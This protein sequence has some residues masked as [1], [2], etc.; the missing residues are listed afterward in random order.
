[1]KLD[2]RRTTWVYEIVWW[3]SNLIFRTVFRARYFNAER[4]P[5]DGPVILAS[6]HASYMDPPLVGSGIRRPVNY[7]ARDTLFHYRIANFFLRRLLCV[8]VDREGA[9]AA[10][11]K[12]IFDRLSGGGV[13]LLFPEGTRTSDGNLLPARAGIGLTVIKSD[14]PVIP[15]RIFGSYDAYNRRM[16]IPRP[17][18]VM[19][20][21]GNPLDIADLRA[22]VKTC[23]K[24]RVKEIYQEV[25]N[26]IM[27]EIEAME[28][29]TDTNASRPS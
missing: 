22:E 23:S 28:P 21:Y 1:M 24:Q 26:R 27:R 16:L 5:M 11:L 29:C 13:I 14:A 7:L 10:G 18:R 2:P 8:P 19:V 6:N 25:A 3:L 15:I 17:R 9:G 12:G 20:K 4:V